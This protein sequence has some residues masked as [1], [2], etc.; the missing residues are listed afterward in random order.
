ME[1][2][3]RYLLLL[4][5]QRFDVNRLRAATAIT[6]S[7]FVVISA[8][9]GTFL[10]ETC[11]SKRGLVLSVLGQRMFMRWQHDSTSEGECCAVMRT[12][13]GVLQYFGYLVVATEKLSATFLF[14][15]M[16]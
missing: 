9:P 6:E 3:P 14:H 5:I 16:K 12:R 11:S 10:V 15:L 8:K 7:I 1:K 13:P 4:L 2:L